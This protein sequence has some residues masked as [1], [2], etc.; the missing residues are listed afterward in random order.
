VLSGPDGARPMNAG[1]ETT[2]TVA[3]VKELRSYVGI[4]LQGLKE[5]TKK[6]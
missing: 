5:A 6:T 1:L 4:L 2:W 3:I